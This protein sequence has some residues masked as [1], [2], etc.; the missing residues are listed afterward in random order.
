MTG[1]TTATGVTG[2]LT[3]GTGV[4]PIT[5]TKFVK[6]FIADVLLSGAAALAAA[7]ILDVGSAIQTPEVAAFALV[8]AVIRAAYRAALR[9]STT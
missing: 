8:G 1:I 2:A 7:Q 9:W 4:S 6:D 5:T 3:D